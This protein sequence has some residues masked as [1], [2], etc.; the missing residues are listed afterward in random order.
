MVE[1]LGETS[2]SGAASLK[3]SDL[4]IL[5]LSGDRVRH[6]DHVLQSLGA[7]QGL[8]IEPRMAASSKGYQEVNG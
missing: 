6:A 1:R 2:G 8:P 7:Y 5:P 4:V 3:S